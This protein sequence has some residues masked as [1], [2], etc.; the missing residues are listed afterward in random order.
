MRHGNGARDILHIVV[1]YQSRMKFILPALFVPHLKG[2]AIGRYRYIIGPVSNITARRPIA[3]HIL[4]NLMSANIT[5]VV[6]QEY[7]ALCRHRIRQLKLGADDVL[8]RVKAL[9]MLRPDRSDDSVVRMHQIADLLDIPH[10]SG[11][12]LADKNLMKRL[13]LLSDRPH[14]TQR[15]IVV[16]RCL[17]HIKSAGQQCIQEIF[18]TGLAVTARHADHR[19]IRHLPQNTGRI[20]HIMPVDSLL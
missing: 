16:A 18:H 19:Q 20:R 1:A 4:I 8:Y 12:H 3:Y 10:F 5:V 17:Q 14:H 13:H 15:R 9:Q 6:I 2:G 11:A 7:P